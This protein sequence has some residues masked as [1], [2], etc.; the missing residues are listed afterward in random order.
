MRY[1]V[2]FEKLRLGDIAEVGGKNA[3]LG[4]LIAELTP[5]G[6]GVPRGFALSVR[7]FREHLFK[8]GLA[9]HIYSALAALDPTDVAELSKLGAAIRCQIRE[10]PLPRDV[11]Q[12]LI[13]S[14]RELSLSY[15]EPET[16]VAVRSSATAADAL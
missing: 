7:A 13:R 4:E 5:Q 1:T 3:S 15:G 11:E 8:A 9:E 14:Y 10:A 16:D 2:P 12:E 6:I